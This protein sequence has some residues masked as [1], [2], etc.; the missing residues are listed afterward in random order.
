L[1]IWPIGL[2]WDD[3]NVFNLLAT[4]RR[5]YNGD[6]NSKTFQYYYGTLQKA[7][8][9]AEGGKRAI[10]PNIPLDAE[11]KDIIIVNAV[12]MAD[13]VKAMQ[14]L[15]RRNQV[16]ER[17]FMHPSLK[18]VRLENNLST[19]R[20]KIVPLGKQ[21]LKGHLM[22]SANFFKL[23]EDQGRSPASP[24]LSAIDALLGLPD[25]DIPLRLLRGIV[26][27]P[28]LLK[29][30]S[31]LLT[32]GYHE[33]SGLY[34]EP[35][36]GLN[37]PSVS[38]NPSQEDIKEAR[39]WLD[40]EL[41]GDFPFKDNASKVNYIALLLTPFLRNMIPVVPMAL[42]NTPEMGTGKSMLA[43]IVAEITV[44]EEPYKEADIPKANDEVKKKITSV[45]KNAY[46]I[47]IFDNVDGTINSPV[48]AS[49]LT[50]PRWSDRLLGGNNTIEV[51]QQLTWIATGNNIQLGKD[52]GRRVYEIFLDAGVV[53]PWERRGFKHTPLKSWV[54]E[55]QGNLIWA[56]LT[57]IRA[58][59]IAGSPTFTNVTLGSFEEWCGYIGGIVT[60]AGYADFLA[61]RN[62]T[63]R[64]SVAE[65]NN[66][67]RG[68]FE[69]L[70]LVTRNIPFL[71]K[72]IANN[73]L[74]GQYKTVNDNL[75]SA[76]QQ[77]M[78]SKPGTFGTTLGNFLSR[79]RLRRFI[80]N[81]I[82]YYLDAS[83]VN[84]KGASLWSFRQG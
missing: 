22:K 75:P 7:K 23:N 66:E 61:N 1:P 42:I 81:D 32:A 55:N 2:A 57:L 58:W 65:E 30:G 72:D 28:V 64:R 16:E 79:H 35:L 27:V 38:D 33:P 43:E 4:A 62:E 71:A 67:W 6:V 53:N 60:N 36:S 63:Y 9:S 8:K 48:L 18:I 37:I 26:H 5:T 77:A 51:E 47:C 45:I 54:K 49:A 39:H 21:E 78:K 68:F 19:G 41:L 34:Y 46:S 52:M 74:E 15:L 25:K 24:P 70:Y 80:V 31:F 14:A 11:Y 56:L 82:T 10:T 20:L 29:D 76:L 12:Q 3:Q 59:I 13:I 40:D 83:G 44:G 73:I 50:S 69:A 17:L 84:G